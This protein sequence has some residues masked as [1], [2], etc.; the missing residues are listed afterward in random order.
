MWA[1]KSQPQFDTTTRQREGIPLP[2]TWVDIPDPD[3]VEAENDDL[4]VYKQGTARGG[5]TFRRLEGCL[6]GRGKIFF[7]STSGGDRKLG[8][9]WEYTP[10]SETNGGTL[11]LLLEPSDPNLLNMPDN[12][13]L[14]RRG[15]LVICEDNSAAVHLKLFSS[16]GEMT[17]LAKN[18][19]PGFESR[20]FA[21]VTF[22]PDG[23]TLFVNI[24]V[25]GF[26]FA[27]WGPWDR[28]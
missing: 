15:G 28:L 4:A 8:Q 11:T 7:T 27:I 13:C 2:V 9:V 3:P 26:T 24:Q 6:Y 22:T 18:V 21:G 20:E 14:T 5:A 16:D 1:I 10:G 12:L 25:P 17:N 19:I 23:E